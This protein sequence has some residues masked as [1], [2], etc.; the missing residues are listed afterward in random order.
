MARAEPLYRQALAIRRK[1]LGEKHPDYANSLN[2]L[3][4]LH[5][6]LG[7][8]AQAEP[9]F[10]QALEIKKEVLGEEHPNYGASLNNLALLHDSMA[11]YA[12]A[13]PLHRASLQTLCKA[14]SKVIPALSEAQALLW[15][16]EQRPRADLLLANLR[17]HTGNNDI[18]PY[19]YVWRTQGLATRLRANRELS[20]G[21][22]PE[23]KRAFAELRDARLKLARL[24]SATPEPAKAK[25]FKQQLFEANANKERLEKKLASLNPATQRAI[26]IRDAKVEDLLALLPAGV[27]VIDI[28]RLHDWRPVAKRVT[29]QREDGG[30]ETRMFKE[31]KG[32]PVYDAF[33]LRG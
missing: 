2:N 16:V 6:S 7:D 5:A 32:T 17:R 27:A 13:E 28:T 1:A 26:A 29:L 21:A 24:V 22:L 9:L 18:R 15:S 31:F 30:Q 8:F 3:A 10:R 25:R 19:T 12:R 11:D 23:A 4:L 20:S 14:A 33:V